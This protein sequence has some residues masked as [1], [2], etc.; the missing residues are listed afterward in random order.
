[1]HALLILL[2][3]AFCLLPSPAAPTDAGGW[4]RL[5]IAK[6]DSGDIDGAL[7]AY[8]KAEAMHFAQPV[9][10]Y[11][12][13]ARAYARAGKND[14]AFA[15]LKRL[16]DLGFA[17]PEILDAQNDLL[18]IRTDPRYAATI[19][20][21]K[22]N[23][24]PCSA[25]EFRQFDFWIGEWDVEA[26]G[27][28]IAYSSIQLI[29]NECAIFENYTAQ[30][31]YSGKS[32]SIYDAATKRWEQ[33]YVDTSGAFHEWTNGGLTPEGQMRFFGRHSGQFDRMTYTKE[34]PDAVRQVLETSTDDGKTWATTY[35][36]LY[37]RRK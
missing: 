36:G 22:K 19:D 24:H 2:L 6:H 29:L 9:P 25:P 34:G 28:K 20:A 23:Q 32:F 21:A 18:P 30:R 35:D 27:A 14:E 3:S 12:R 8:Q 31:G 33:R 10:L 7:A 16:T 17:N 11:I 1:M 5:G 4:F 13:E 37:K 15:A 26:G